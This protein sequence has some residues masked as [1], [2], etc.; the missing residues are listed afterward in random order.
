MILIISIVSPGRVSLCAERQIPTLNLE[1]LPA[2]GFCAQKIKEGGNYFVSFISY[3]P[4]LSS[5]KTFNSFEQK[6][7]IGRNTSNVKICMVI[8]V[9][10]MSKY[11]TMYENK[12]VEGL[13]TK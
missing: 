9:N 1:W 3:Y 6:M 11:P 7:N 4:V 12:I 10:S 8:S 5:M 13:F 2:A